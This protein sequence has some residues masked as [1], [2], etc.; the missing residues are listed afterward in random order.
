[1]YIYFFF[2]QTFV[3]V[4]DAVEEYIC[5][6]IYMYIYKYICVHYMYIYVYVYMCTFSSQLTFEM[7]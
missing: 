4:A 5:I 1:M 2:C 3:Y 7:S 6:P